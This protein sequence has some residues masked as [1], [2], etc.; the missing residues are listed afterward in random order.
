MLKSKRR[1]CRLMGERQSVKEAFVWVWLCEAADKGLSDATA[2]S[3]MRRPGQLTSLQ[4]LGHVQGCVCPLIEQSQE[5]ALRGQEGVKRAEMSPEAKQENIKSY[6]N[7]YVILVF[8]TCEHILPNL[9]PSNVNCSIAKIIHSRE[10]TGNNSACVAEGKNLHQSESPTDSDCT[11]NLGQPIILGKNLT[12]LLALLLAYLTDKKSIKWIPRLAC[13]F[14]V[15]SLSGI[16]SW[17][18]TAETC[19]RAF[20]FVKTEIIS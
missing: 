1:R 2:G 14:S 15:C 8:I 17:Y 6:I 3:C 12:F 20:I 18:R 7:V 5:M 4:P 16:F 9:K 10:V 19:L 13:S 11:R